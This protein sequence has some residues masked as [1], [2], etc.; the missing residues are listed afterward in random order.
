MK[1]YQK[2]TLTVYGRVEEITATGCFRGKTIGLPSD[3]NFTFFGHPIPISD[4]EFS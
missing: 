3:V 1:S 2:P 4:C